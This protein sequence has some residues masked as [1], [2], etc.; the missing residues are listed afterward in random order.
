MKG[1]VIISGEPSIVDLLHAHITTQA[2]N[3]W[4]EPTH[5]YIPIHY[6]RRRICRWRHLAIYTIGSEGVEAECLK[7]FVSEAMAWGLPIKH[8]VTLSDYSIPQS[9]P[10]VDRIA[11]FPLI[12]CHPPLQLTQTQSNSPLAPR[13][14]FMPSSGSDQ[15]REI[16]CAERVSTRTVKSL[17]VSFLHMS[18]TSASS[19]VYNCLFRC[20]SSLFIPDVPW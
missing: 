20:K 9:T 18:P 11:Q 14:G 17:S 19:A 3:K 4:T 13:T 12:S 5:K 16:I 7:E 1:E 2:K 10:Y 15:Q 6:S 8:P